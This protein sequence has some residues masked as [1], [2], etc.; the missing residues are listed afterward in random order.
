[1]TYY[2]PRAHHQIP[3][4]QE[5]GFNIRNL[6][7]TFNLQRYYS[8]QHFYN[9]LVIPPAPRTPGLLSFTSLNPNN[10]THSSIKNMVFQYNYGIFFIILSSTRLS[11]TGNSLTGLDQPVL[12]FQQ[13]GTRSKFPI[14]L[15]RQWLFGTSGVNFKF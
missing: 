2:F 7:V 11:K 9:G 13:N 15:E 1:M 3:S 12:I 10:V 5:L 8:S 6:N 14:D 4:H